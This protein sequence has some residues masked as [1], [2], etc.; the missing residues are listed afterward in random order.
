MVMPKKKSAI[1]LS[2]L[3]VVLPLI[4]L[5]LETLASVIMGLPS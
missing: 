3:W 1:F 4:V 2:E 5:P